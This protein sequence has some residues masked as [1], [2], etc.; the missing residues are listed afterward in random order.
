MQW[1]GKTET[2]YL[3]SHKLDM[4]RKSW[5]HVDL[6]F[7]SFS[8]QWKH[9]A[10][11][12]LMS[13]RYTKRFLPLVTVNILTQAIQVYRSMM[14]FVCCYSHCQQLQKSRS[15]HGKMSLPSIRLELYLVDWFRTFIYGSLTAHVW[16]FASL[17]IKVNWSFQNIATVCITSSWTISH[18]ISFVWEGNTQ[19]WQVVGGN[20]LRRSDGVDKNELLLELVWSATIGHF[21][22]LITEKA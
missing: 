13:E 16:D 19:A 11:L 2:R 18:L 3:L 20:G 14:Q 6:A 5:Q 21:L 17:R 9:K 12:W 15:I 1:N 22:E 8:Y 10:N 7:R 4:H